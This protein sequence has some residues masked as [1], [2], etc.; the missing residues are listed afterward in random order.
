MLKNS[1]AYVTGASQGIGRQISI[2][3]AEEGANVA[4]AARSEGIYETAEIIDNDE[5]TLPVK[6]DVTVEGSVKESLEKTAEEFGSID[7]LVN[8]AGISGPT[9]PVEK[10]S[11]EEWD[12][13]MDVNVKGVFLVIK[14][15]VPFLKESDQARI[16]NIASTSGKKPLENR[17]PYTTSKMAVIGLTR[18]LAFELGNEGVTVNSI[19]PGTVRGQ[20]A[21]NVI[22]KRADDLGISYEEAKRKLFVD[23]TALESMVDAESVA[24]QVVYLASDKGR[25]ITAQDI[26]VDAGGAWY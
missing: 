2:S 3:L 13:T 21:K 14:H 19:C 11:T 6:T 12:K 4:L 17:T 10:I 24:N 1:T 5:K 8:N 7:I 25:D 9:S 23:D 22:K 15:G 16:I 20:R 18:T 26:N